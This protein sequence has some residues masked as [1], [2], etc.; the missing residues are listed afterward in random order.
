[1]TVINDIYCFIRNTPFH[2]WIVLACLITTMYLTII[3]IEIDY[4]VAYLLLCLVTISFAMT[5]G[6]MVIIMKRFVRFSTID[7]IVLIW[8]IYIEARFW[9]DDTYPAWGVA[10]KST[11]AVL[12]YVSMRMLISSERRVGGIIVTSFISFSLIE[13]FIGYLQLISG[14]SRHH[15]YPVTGSFP[16]PGPYSVYLAMGLVLLLALRKTV[17]Q[18]SKEN[19]DYDFAF[20]LFYEGYY[21]KHIKFAEIL[22]TIFLMIIAIPLALTMS[23]AA[24]VAIAICILIMYRNRIRGWKQRSMVGTI[25]V[26]ISVLLYIFKPGS[27]DGRGIINYIGAKCVAGNPWFGNGIGSFLHCYAEETARLCQNGITEGLMKVD[28]IDY[29]F[30]DLLFVVVEQ[31]FVGLILAIT[32]IIV[33]LSRLWYGNRTLFLAS[34]SLLIISLFSYPFELLPYQIIAVIIAA[35]ASGISYRIPSVI[36]CKNKN[37]GWRNRL[38]IILTVFIVFMLS[39]ALLDAVQEIRKAEKEYTMISGIHD[40]TFIKDYY[41]LLPQLEGDKHFLFDF[42]VILAK[43]GRYNDSLDILRQ[44]ALIS[45]D[46]MFLVL[47]G[48]NY[49]DMGAFDKAK[50]TYLKAWHTM[51]NR[52]YPLYRLMLLYQQTGNDTKTI[53]YAEKIITFKEKISSPAVSDIKREAQEIINKNATLKK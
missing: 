20:S 14:T 15:L 35:Y 27:A 3:P 19:R 53:E 39:N 5:G 41:R 50:E 40:S 2:N 22:L 18:S 24:F 13:A 12:L 38:K 21:L 45:N 44:G 23:R 36:L 30:N 28:V 49:R 16:N 25:A 8:Y 34:L 7:W 51:P 48:N 43:A 11:L 46:P 4:N 42:G 29:A 10:V 52:I 1:M 26:A 9:I 37:Y 6:A 47:Q 31:G 17:T 32:L 33:V